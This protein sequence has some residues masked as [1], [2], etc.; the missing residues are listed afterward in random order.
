MCDG[1][2]RALGLLSL[3]KTQMDLGAVFC[4]LKGR[5]GRARFLEVHRERTRGKTHML[6]QEKKISDF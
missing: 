3:Q 2:R 5:K 6:Q 4:W 1:R